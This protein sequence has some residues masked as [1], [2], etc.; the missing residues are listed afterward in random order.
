[1]KNSYTTIY[2]KDQKIS[3]I[4]AA[5][6]ESDF[7]E[8]ALLG[9]TEII[10]ESVPKRDIPY[11][12]GVSRL[13]LEFEATFAFDK[14]MSIYEIR[15]YVNMFYSNKEYQPLAFE[16]EDGFM[17][18][19]YYAIVEGEP[20]I[21]YIRTDTDKYVGYFKFN[22]RCNAPYGFD[23][24]Y[25]EG[26]KDEFN[27]YLNSSEETEYYVIKIENK[28]E[29][30]KDVVVLT[31]I[32]TGQTFTFNDVEGGEIITIDGRNKRIV[33]TDEDVNVYSKWEEWNTTSEF[34]KLVSGR[35]NFT[36]DEGFNIE[37]TYRAPRFI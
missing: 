19:I 23:E 8:E 13:P 24:G 12:Y 10:E 36:V 3:G 29:G 28:S 31:N 25:Y 4:F 22:F 2:Y 16:R 20:E 18:P 30:L 34:I 11:F 5:T 37:I 17:T 9:A 33:S 32:S 35:N 7:Y 26:D 15:E 27:L 21:E 1:M 14:P 6:L